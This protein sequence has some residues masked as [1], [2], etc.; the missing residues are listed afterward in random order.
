VIRHR[1]ERAREL[2]LEIR[3][4]NTAEIVRRTAQIGFNGWAF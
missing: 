4:A 2:V 3:Q 1:R